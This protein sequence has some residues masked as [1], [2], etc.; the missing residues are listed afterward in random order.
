MET[1]LNVQ[2]ANQDFSHKELLVENVM[3]DV[4]NVLNNLITVKDVN[5]DTPY[6]QPVNVLFVLTILTI[7]KTVRNATTP[8][9]MDVLNVMKDIF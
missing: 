2:V 7:T 9:N 1:T 8:M 6:H 4:V 3:I 5:Q